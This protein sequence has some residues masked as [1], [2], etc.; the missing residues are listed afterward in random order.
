[1]FFCCC[2]TNEHTSRGLE[3]HPFITSQLLCRSVVPDGVTESEPPRPES[4][5][6]SH[7]ELRP[8]STCIPVLGRTQFLAGSCQTEVPV[9]LLAVSPGVPLSSLRLPTDFSSRGPSIFKPGP[10]HQVFLTSGVS[11]TS[12]LNRLRDLCFSELVYLGQAHPNNLHFFF[13]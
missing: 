9:S 3:Q 8:P 13:F 4:R 6:C 2:V 1:M 5:L 11:G 7:R 12:A 10:T